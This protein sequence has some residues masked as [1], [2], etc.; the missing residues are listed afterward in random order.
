MSQ[1]VGAALC[2]VGAAA[3]LYG[4]LYRMRQTTA[5]R[6][7]DATRAG[8]TPGPSVTRSRD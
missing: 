2:L 3:S 8:S 7:V 5:A 6:S 4:L 1:P